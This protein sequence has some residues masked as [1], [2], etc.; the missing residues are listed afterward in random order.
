MQ[1]QQRSTPNWS[2]WNPMRSSSPSIRMRRARPVHPPPACRYRASSCVAGR[3]ILPLFSL[4]RVPPVVR[5]PRLAHSEHH[6]ATVV[7]H[8]HEFSCKDRV[9]QL[10]HGHSFSCDK[11]Q[12]PCRTQGLIVGMP[13]FDSGSTSRT[14][15]LKTK[16]DKTRF[17]RNQPRPR[18][19]ASAADSTSTL[20]RSAVQPVSSLPLKMGVKASCARGIEAIA[21]MR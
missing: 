16:F 8:G 4:T 11:P 14:S 17:S 13:A 7:A 19:T 21:H 15:I 20:V 1:I 3:P 5:K 6:L 18:W 2:D 10:R 12:S 9:R